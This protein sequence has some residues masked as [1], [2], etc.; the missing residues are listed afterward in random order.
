M[1]TPLHILSVDDHAYLRTFL[2][3][4]LT[5]TCPS[6]NVVVEANGAEALAVQS[7]AAA[8]VRPG[9]GLERGLHQRMYAR[10]AATHGCG[11][12]GYVNLEML[13]HDLP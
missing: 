10:H 1:P 5:Q 6:A 2:A 3:R 8:P 7:T 13:D 11:Q 4:L 12:G 9:A